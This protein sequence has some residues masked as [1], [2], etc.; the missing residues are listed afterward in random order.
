[1]KTGRAQSMCIRI[2]SNWT[3]AVRLP[4][5]TLD[6]E[7]QHSE[8]FPLSSIDNKQTTV[9]LFWKLLF[10]V[11][12]IE[13]SLPVDL[14]GFED[15]LC[16]CLSVCVWKTVS[17]LDYNEQPTASQHCRLTGFKSN[18]QA[19]ISSCTQEILFIKWKDPRPESNT[20]MSVQ[21]DAFI[22][23]ASHRNPVK[24]TVKGKQF[25]LPCFFNVSDTVLVLPCVKI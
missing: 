6:Q 24:S 4:V 23:T 11:N 10:V 16:V 13:E 15:T 20:A 14:E 7:S 25:V 22:L 12:L 8:I 21:F 3:C 5:P 18:F 9:G 17:T 2:E 1:M 19:L